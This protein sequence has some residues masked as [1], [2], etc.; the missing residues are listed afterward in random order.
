MQNM[1]IMHAYYTLIHM[2]AYIYVCQIK[3]YYMQRRTNELTKNFFIG[4]IKA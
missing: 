2:Y 1:H 4:Q 3:L